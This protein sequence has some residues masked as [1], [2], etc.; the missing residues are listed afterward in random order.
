MILKKTIWLLL[1]VVVFFLFFTL[2]QPLLGSVVY[3]IAGTEKPLLLGGIAFLL[4]VMIVVY[5]T[6]LNKLRNDNNRR[7]YLM[8][9]KRIYPGLEQDLLQ[10]V[11]SKSYR[12]EVLPFMVLWALYVWKFPQTLPS[13]VFL[14]KITLLGLGIFPYALGCLF[15]QSSVHRLWIDLLKVPEESTEATRWR[16]FNGYHLRTYLY[17][18]AMVACIFGFYLINPY[19]VT[20]PVCVTPALALHFQLQ[21]YKAIGERKTR[22]TPYKKYLWLQIISA[23]LYIFAFLFGVFAPKVL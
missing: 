7:T 23:I 20:L 2:L 17:Q 6:Y 22:N 18:F 21:G 10:I 13:P 15:L 19:L 4:S 9:T 14:S 11:E 5:A 3:S 8:A 12:W 1:I 16:K